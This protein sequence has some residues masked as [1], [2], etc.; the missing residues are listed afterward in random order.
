MTVLSIQ[1]WSLHDSEPD[2]TFSGDHAGTFYF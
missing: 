1:Y 2:D